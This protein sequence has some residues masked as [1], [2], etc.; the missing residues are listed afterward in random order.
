MA[1]IDIRHDA[2]TVPTE[3]N[4]RALLAEYSVVDVVIRVN[5]AGLHLHL[6]SSAAELWIPE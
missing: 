4:I 2:A 6:R 5:H 3:R 1:E